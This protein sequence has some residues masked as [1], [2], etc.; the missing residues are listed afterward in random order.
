M[1]GR[2]SGNRGRTKYQ[3]LIA[4]L[5]MQRKQDVT[6]T[7]A[8]I[9][10]LIGMPLSVSATNNPRI[11]SGTTYTYVARWQEMGWRA[12]LNSKRQCVHFTR[13]TEEG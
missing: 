5:A 9:E 6:L 11:W 1:A 8:D 10:K 3:P 4:F 12:R 13:A 7:L 2:G